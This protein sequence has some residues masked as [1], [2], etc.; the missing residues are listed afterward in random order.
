MFGL[1]S[2]DR[3]ETY[4]KELKFEIIA[5]RF[6]SKF[7]E[8]DIIAKGKNQILHFIEVKA[9]SGEYEVEYRLTPSKYVKI[10]KAVDYY[11][12]KNGLDSDFQIDLLVIKKEKIE[13]IE[14]ISL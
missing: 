4:L 13:L 9:T 3:A 6:C 5:R 2:E 14:N 10:L 11:L 7:G 8:I 1:S 12:M